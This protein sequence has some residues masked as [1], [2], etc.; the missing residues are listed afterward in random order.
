MLEALVGVRFAVRGCH[1][2]FPLPL[3]APGPV[4]SASVSHGSDTPVDLTSPHD[5]VDI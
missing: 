1:I 3:K 4:F 5:I 2:G